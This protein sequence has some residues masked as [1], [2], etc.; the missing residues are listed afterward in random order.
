MSWCVLSWCGLSW[1]G[2]SW[3]GL[4]W[5]GLRSERYRRV[6]EKEEERQE[7]A[8]KVTSVRRKRH[9]HKAKRKKR[10]GRQ[11]RSKAHLSQRRCNAINGLASTDR[12]GSIRHICNGVPIRIGKEM[13]VK[14]KLV[15]QEKAPCEQQASAT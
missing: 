8:T 7:S 3:C 2:L 13:L 14:N 6:Y 12:Q 15:L 11:K 9:E 5:C 10:N 4:S 1:C